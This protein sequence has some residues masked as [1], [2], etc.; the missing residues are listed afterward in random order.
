[1]FQALS[2]NRDQYLNQEQSGALKGLLAVAVLLCHVVPMSGVFY[3]SILS[4]LIGSLGYLSVA[5]FFFLSG[6]GIMAQYHSKKEQYLNTFLKNRVL[7]IYFLTLFLIVV[8]SIFHISIGA[9][10][11]ATIFIQ[12]F[13]I[14]NSVVSNGWYLQVVI[15]FYVFW[16]LT[17][18]YTRIQQTQ[19]VLLCVLI[20][21]YMVIGFYFMDH[22][23]YQSSLGFLLGIFWQQKK[24]KLDDWLFSSKK[25]QIAVIMTAFFTFAVTYI[26]SVKGSFINPDITAIVKSVMSCSSAAA[27][28]ILTV[29]IN[30]VLG[31][32]LNCKVLR[33]LGKYSMDIY[34][35]QGIPLHLFKEG[36]LGVSNGLL[37]IVTVCAATILLSVTIHPVTQL[38][39]NIPRK[40]I[41]KG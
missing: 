31:A 2:V 20:I 37:Y 22:F 38:V 14:G 34:V 33:F 10:I 35:F 3:G 24:Q 32:L 28:V 30:V 25:H 18:K 36:V 27:F 4:P 11:S 8:Y 12:S 29:L 5:V 15:L 7:S 9:K 13:F 39:T 16:Y 6:Y 23:R 41:K 21:G 19:F 40:Y 26:L 1:M 17:I